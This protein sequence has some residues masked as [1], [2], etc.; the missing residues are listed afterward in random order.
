MGLGSANSVQHQE[1]A[2]AAHHLVLEVVPVPDLEPVVVVPLV[3]GLEE[4]ELVLEV[5]EEVPDLEPE[6]EALETPPVMEVYTLP[7]AST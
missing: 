6:P 3:L 2:A 5:A 1:L 4:V 7:T